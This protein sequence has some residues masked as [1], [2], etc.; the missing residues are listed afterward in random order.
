M[1][2][3]EHVTER[4][5]VSDRGVSSV[6]SIVHGHPNLSFLYIQSPVCPCLQTHPSIIFIIT[7]DEPRCSQLNSM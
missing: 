4:E 3:A 2:M 7:G 1:P 6:Q 5:E